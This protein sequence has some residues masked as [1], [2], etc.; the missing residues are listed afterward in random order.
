MKMTAR[1]C[2]VAALSV[3]GVSCASDNDMIVLKHRNDTGD[4]KGGRQD[5]GSTLYGKDT[6]VYVT[7]VEFPDDY[8]WQCHQK[9]C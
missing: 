1:M 8:F 9:K 3:I 7:A 5:G 4:W 6:V 2:L